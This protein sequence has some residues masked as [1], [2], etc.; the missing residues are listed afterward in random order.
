MNTDER[1]RTEAAMAKISRMKREVEADP[2]AA[3]QASLDA[4]MAKF[5]RRLLHMLFW[6]LL[7]AA[8]AVAIYLRSRS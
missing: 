6:V 5:R 4:S 3:M 7:V 8:L 1:R 2:A